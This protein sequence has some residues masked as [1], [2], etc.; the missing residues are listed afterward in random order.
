SLGQV[1]RKYREEKRFIFRENLPTLPFSE[2]NSRRDAMK[3]LSLLL[4][5]F[6]SL[7]VA[8][9]PPGMADS[10][11]VSV[12]PDKEDITVDARGPIHE[13]YAAPVKVSPRPGP[14]VDTKPPE[15]INELPPD[16]KP[17]GDNI[18]WVPGYWAW[19]GDRNDYVWVSGFWRAPPPNRKWVP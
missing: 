2:Q 14:V 12:S 6:L 17:E 19:D 11:I 9:V 4:I 15:P 10:K 1:A 13:A 3:S 7:A 8:I 5:G 16:Q 18:Q